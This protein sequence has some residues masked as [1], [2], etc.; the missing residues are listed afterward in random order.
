M[1]KEVVLHL[2]Q[3][4]DR[5]WLK[6]RTGVI[7]FEECWPLGVNLKYPMNTPNDVLSQL[8][9]VARTVKVKDAAGLGAL[10]YAYSEGDFSTLSG[11]SS[12]D[13][14]IKFIA[15]AIKKPDEF[16]IWAQNESRDENRLRLLETARKAYSKGGW[17]WDKAFMLAAAFL[18]VTNGIPEVYT[19]DD[20]QSAEFPYWVALDKHTP[21]GKKA[22]SKAAEMLGL[23]SKKIIWVSFYLE[24]A[25]TNES[26]PSEWWILETEWR[27]RKIGLDFE[28][29][30]SIWEKAK[31]VVMEYLQD[32]SNWLR[33]H[34]HG[35]P[36]QLRLL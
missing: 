24:S 18:T 2:H 12:F 9:S 34:I 22:L 23:P 5:S 30:R 27:L 7:T 28:E 8:E 31:P 20:T 17:P 21:Q 35:E 11:K 26:L 14:A 19:V 29:A 36:T 25:K 4:D 15:E 33:G 6:Q 32:D 10:A 16:W 1:V 13:K 3:I